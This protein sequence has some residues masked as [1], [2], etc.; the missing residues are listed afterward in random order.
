MSSSSV[1]NPT[2]D[3]QIVNHLYDYS[4]NWTPL[5]LIAIIIIYFNLWFWTF[6]NYTSEVSINPPVE[7]VAQGASLWLELN[8]TELMAYEMQ[9]ELPRSL[10]SLALQLN[11]KIKLI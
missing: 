9:Q 11:Y 4:P 8:W 1:C 6:A 5:G 3:Q 7:P 2:C 10:A